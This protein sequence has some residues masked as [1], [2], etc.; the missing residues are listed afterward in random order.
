M[1]VPDPKRSERVLDKKRKLKKF[2]SLCGKI[3]IDENAVEKLREI[4][5]M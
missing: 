5:K 1:P 2:F 3:S 4:S